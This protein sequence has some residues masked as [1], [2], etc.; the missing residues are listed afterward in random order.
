MPTDYPST[1]LITTPTYSRG[2]VSNNYDSS[3]ITPASGTDFNATT[4]TSGFDSSG[5][6]FIETQTL[7]IEY[8]RMPWN[9][10]NYGRTQSTDYS[11]SGTWPNNTVVSGVCGA[12]ALALH[13]R[14]A[15]KIRKSNQLFDT[16][17]YYQP[18]VLAV[19]AFNTD[20]NGVAYGTSGLGG[21][22]VS[23]RLGPRGDLVSTS[24]FHLRRPWNA[25]EDAEINET[26]DGYNFWARRPKNNYSTTEHSA[27]SALNYDICMSDTRPWNSL[28]GFRECGVPADNAY[29]PEF[30]A[31][32]RGESF[33]RMNG[34]YNPVDELLNADRFLAD[35]AQWWVGSGHNMFHTDAI[36]GANISGNLGTRGAAWCCPSYDVTRHSWS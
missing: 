8:V 15:V 19:Q 12:T 26:M 33:L 7:S 21:V 30:D 18:Q 10:Q 13:V 1:P 16:S 28:T 34:S 5:P 25:A 3:N 23:G 9:P 2:E 4:A 6:W 36:F 31:S 22:D 32:L 20:V 29:V 27:V 14:A 35:Q 17:A 11:L 24:D